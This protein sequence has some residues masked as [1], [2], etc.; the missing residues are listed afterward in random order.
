MIIL[1]LISDTRD[2]RTFMARF[3]WRWRHRCSK[4][5]QPRTISVWRVRRRRSRNLVSRRRWWL[6]RWRRKMFKDWKRN[7]PQRRRRRW[8]ASPLRR[9][10]P[11]HYNCKHTRP[12]WSQNSAVKRAMK[13]RPL[14]PTERLFVAGN[15]YQ[16][17]RNLINQCSSYNQAIT[18]ISR[19]KWKVLPQRQ[20]PGY[21]VLS[22]KFCHR[23]W[24]SNRID[25]KRANPRVTPAGSHDK[26]VRKK[27]RKVIL[28]N[29]EIE[30]FPVLSTIMKI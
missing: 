17:K 27:V 8:I 29:L 23:V 25:D 22:E 6:F 19:I 10:F 12:G 1:Q 3:A 26:M 30:W 24:S 20:T 18:R 9:Y 28:P 4:H 14:C 5:S 21:L 13:L 2:R 15:E 11:R 16:D 7:C